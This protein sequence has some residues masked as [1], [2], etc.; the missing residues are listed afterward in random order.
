LRIGNCKS[1]ER[2]SSGPAIVWAG[3]GLAP[4][5]QFSIFNFQFSIFN[6][7]FSRELV[8]PGLAWLPGKE[9]S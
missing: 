1:A 6:A 2:P 5:R 9:P 4:R 3:N 8:R 7:A